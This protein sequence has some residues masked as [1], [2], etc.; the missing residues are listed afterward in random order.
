M[1]APAAR[2]AVL[3]R[4]ASAPGRLAAEAARVAAAEAESGVPAGE[5]TPAQVLAHL[6]AVEREVWQARLA[7]LG[8]ATEPEWRWTEPGPVADPRAATADGASALFA[9]ARAATLERLAALDEPGWART[10]VHATFGRLDVVGLLAV[11]ASHDDEHLEA[12]RA[13]A[14]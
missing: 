6:V 1:T 2:A 4:L 10:G 11:A 14:Q 12:L 9:D 3:D 13:R 5:W 7:M 8:G